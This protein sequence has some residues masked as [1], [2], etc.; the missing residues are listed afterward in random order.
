M[1]AKLEGYNKVEYTRNGEDKSFVSISVSTDKKVTYGSE[2]LNIV[3][4]LKYWNEKI[5]P[6]FEAHVPVHVGYDKKNGN[7]PFLYVKG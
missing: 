2:Y 3:T 1:L 5:S 7:K 4:G 6:A